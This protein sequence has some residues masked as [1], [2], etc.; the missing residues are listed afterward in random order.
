M[1]VSYVALSKQCLWLVSC[2]CTLITQATCKRFGHYGQELCM[3]LMQ[4][5]RK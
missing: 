4:N 5:A 2:D 1:H 3:T